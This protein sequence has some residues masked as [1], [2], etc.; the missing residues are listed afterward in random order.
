MQL[1]YA[2]EVTQNAVCVLACDFLK[3]ERLFLLPV[4]GDTNECTAVTLSHD[5][6]LR[7][8]DNGS[9]YVLLLS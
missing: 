2:H 8:M 6:L 1:T 5:L 9:A 4:L 3:Q 7:N